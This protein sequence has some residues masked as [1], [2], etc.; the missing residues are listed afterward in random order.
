VTVLLDEAAMPP[1]RSV[2]TRLLASA[3]EADFA[4]SRV[5]LAAIDLSAAEAAAIGRCRFLLGRLEAEVLSD[6]S[7]GA[8]ADH[9][10]ALHALLRSGRIEIRSAG[11]HAWLPDFSIFRGVRG[12]TAPGALGIIGAHYFRQPPVTDGPSITCILA[13]RQGVDILSRRFESLWNAAHDVQ[14]AVLDTV[15]RNLRAG[16][17]RGR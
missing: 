16:R 11:M 3:G 4:V 8:G 10:T 5:R 12:C 13:E 17:S 6:F 14:A 15:E 9:L 7:A 1:V 2:L